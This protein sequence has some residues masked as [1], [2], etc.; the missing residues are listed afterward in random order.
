MQCTN[1]LKQIGLAIHNYEGANGSLPPGAL[2]LFLNGNVNSPT[3]YNNHGPSVHARML[4]Y[5]EQP[6]LFNALN[7]NVGI[8]NDVTG[9]AMNSTVTTTVINGFLCPSSTAP[10]WNFQGTDAVL[11][12]DRAPGNNYFAS[13]GSSLE[14]AGQQTGGPPNGPFSYVGTLGHVTRL[15][16][17][18]D[19]LSNS[20]GF[21][22]WKTGSGSP[23]A[24]SGQ[25][26]VF[27]GTFPAGT[28]R[29]NGTLNMAH[30]ILVASFQPWLQ[31]CS[32]TWQSGGGRFGKT[33]T[34]GEAWSLGLMGYSLGNV[35]LGPN[36]KY[37]NC[38]TNGAGTI[39]SVGVF[40]LSS[41]H[42]GGANVLFLDGSVR[43]LKDGVDNAAVWS[44]GSI[45]QGEIVSSDSF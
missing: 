34:L 17:I 41:Y 18:R 35:L 27:T 33:D 36:S 14:F 10:S 8:F 23:N 43:F 39:Q 42:P 16:D 11:L 20:I 9:D 30:P 4:N 26:V 2:A 37:P 24:L 25:D 7:F 12:S 38:N 40:G 3:F 45:G 22:E 28:A 6:G 21:G 5:L 44:L 32:Q 29:N 31:Q 19:G 1:N 13:V 15:S